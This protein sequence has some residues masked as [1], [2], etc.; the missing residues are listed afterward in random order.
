[1]DLSSKLKAEEDKDRKSIWSR[2]SFR[3][4]PQSGGGTQEGMYLDDLASDQIDPEVYA[5][6]FPER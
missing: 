6:Y 1:M 3:R 4:G 2:W 5:L